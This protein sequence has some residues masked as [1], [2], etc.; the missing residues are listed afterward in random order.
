[1]E[2]RRAKAG[3]GLALGKASHV[4]CEKGV[5]EREQADGVGE[6]RLPTHSPVF[7]GRTVIPGC[8]D[9]DDV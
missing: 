5:L 1:M 8:T 7:F 2:T 6:E 9:S 3:R 4:A